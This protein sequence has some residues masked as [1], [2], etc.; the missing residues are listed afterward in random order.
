MAKFRTYIEESITELVHKVSWPTWK[1]L[2]DSSVIVL[3]AS[4]IIAL[5]VWAMD[6]VFGING[7]KSFWSGLLG[8]FYN[9]K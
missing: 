6:Y 7:A 1:E 2:Q 4:V 3:V 8:L 5:T 9:F